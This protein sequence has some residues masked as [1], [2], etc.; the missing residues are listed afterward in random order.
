[1]KLLFP[2]SFR[3]QNGLYCCAFGCTLNYK[4]GTCQCAEY[5]MLGS[6]WQHGKTSNSVPSS[7]VSNFTVIP[8]WIALP[9]WKPGWQRNV[10]LSRMYLVQKQTVS[11]K[12]W[13]INTSN[14]V[15]RCICVTLGAVSQWTSIHYVRE[16]LDVGLVI[17][18]QMWPANELAMGSDLTGGSLSSCVVFQ[19]RWCMVAIIRATTI[20]VLLAVQT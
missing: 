13:Q 16:C 8:S 18:H 17:W 6:Q 1:M 9:D 7:F 2:K 19:M 10:Y 14:E 11:P 15:G 12:H 4:T 3:Q 5:Q 20:A